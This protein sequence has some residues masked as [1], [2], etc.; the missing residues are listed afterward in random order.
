MAKFRIKETVSRTGAPRYHFQKRFGPFW[1]DFAAA[2]YYDNIEKA[3]KF[4]LEEIEKYN[5]YQKSDGPVYYLGKYRIIFDHSLG[6]YTAQQK[7]LFGWGKL[8]H[9]EYSDVIDYS[10]PDT[11]H[12]LKRYIRNNEKIMNA[13]NYHYIES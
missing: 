12:Y 1:F 6:M 3:K 9:T 2:K 8:K 10:L 5:K 13:P 11:L 4:L 7:G